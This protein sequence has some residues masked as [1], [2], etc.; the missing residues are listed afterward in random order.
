MFNASRT[1]SIE[2]IIKSDNW[3][4]DGLSMNP[5]FIKYF[6]E[7]GRFGERINMSIYSRFADPVFIQ[8]HPEMNWF[9]DGVSMNT[10]AI[11]YYEQ[12]GNLSNLIDMKQFS[13]RASSA[14]IL[15]HPEMAWNIKSLCRNPNLNDDI[16]IRYMDDP[17]FDFDIVKE[18]NRQ[19]F[20]IRHPEWDWPKLDLYFE[21]IPEETN[22]VDEADDSDQ[23]DE[24]DQSD[25]SDD[26]DDCMM[27][28]FD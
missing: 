5:N 13:R 25:Q 18:Y 1:A 4:N 19:D 10:R 2:E 8:N 6:E 11:Q 20:M 24:S 12:T 9:A 21:T 17:E 7:T 16:I 14:F 3:D 22:Q 23:S 27:N 28:I 15:A 26:S